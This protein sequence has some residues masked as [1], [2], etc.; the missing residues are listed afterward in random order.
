MSRGLRFTPVQRRHATS[1]LFAAT[2]IA[3]IVVVAS[4]NILPCPVRPNRGRYADSEEGLT[5]Q[6]GGSARPIVARRP[7][8][9][10][11][12]TAPSA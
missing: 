3:A 12:E 2:A 11:E 1:T 6:D 10:I 5:L 7:R 9:W 4:S 8:R